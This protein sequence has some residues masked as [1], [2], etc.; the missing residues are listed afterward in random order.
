MGVLVD[1]SVLVLVCRGKGFRFEYLLVLG[2]LLYVVDYVVCLLRV[3]A[4]FANPPL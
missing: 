3:V 2:C 1:V 4:V